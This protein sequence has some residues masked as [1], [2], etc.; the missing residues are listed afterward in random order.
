MCTYEWIAAIKAR[1]APVNGTH[2]LVAHNISQNEQLKR[3]KSNSKKTQHA[4]ERTNKREGVEICENIF[5]HGLQNR[6]LVAADQYLLV[7]FMCSFLRVHVSK[8]VY[9]SLSLSV[10]MR[11]FSK[12]ISRKSIALK[13]G[14]MYAIWDSQ[15]THHFYAVRERKS[16]TISIKNSIKLP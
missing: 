16:S 2:S 7:C 4:N 15:S 13:H 8:W 12:L 11:V 3:N 9:V 6:T 1:I 5:R 10:C 14:K